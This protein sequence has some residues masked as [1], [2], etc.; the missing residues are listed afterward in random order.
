MGAWEEMNARKSKSALDW[1]NSGNQAQDAGVKNLMAAENMLSENLNAW[2]NREQ[3]KAISDA[4]N[5]NR[6]DQEQLSVDKFETLGRENIP[7]WAELDQQGKIKAL[8]VLMHGSNAANTWSDP[9]K[10]DGGDSLKDYALNLRQQFAGGTEWGS[11]YYIEKPEGGW[12]LKDPKMLEAAKADFLKDLKIALQGESRTRP[13]MKAWLS[14]DKLLRAQVDAMFGTG[15]I[16]AGALSTG[17]NIGTPDEYNQQMGQNLI[18][19]AQKFGIQGI[20]A[21]EG[22]TLAVSADT[23]SQ[24]MFDNYRVA[25]DNLNSLRN[26]AAQVG[27][28]KGAAMWIDYSKLMEQQGQIESKMSILNSV[29]DNPSAN[30]MGMTKEKAW[31]DLLSQVDALVKS[32]NAILTKTTNS[33]QG[34][35]KKPY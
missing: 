15:D 10:K 20:Q 11:K 5:K 24:K 26:M 33:K 22:G 12:T 14:N 28:A 16:E 17:G 34:T 9:N 2:Q 31:A 8:D 29:I 23:N 30:R 4:E 13:E 1:F 18:K 7:G 3:A 35:S 6:L 27:G 21:G 19:I 25:V 32:S